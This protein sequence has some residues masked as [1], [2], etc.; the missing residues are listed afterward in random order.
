MV[1]ALFVSAGLL[2]LICALAAGERV[3][4]PVPIR[5]G[6][7]VRL[8]VRQGVFNTATVIRVWVT[9]GGEEYATVADAAGERY[10]RPTSLLGRP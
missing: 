8:Q 1:A 5:Q 3:P 10:T 4:R 2:W 7:T 6:D 9:K